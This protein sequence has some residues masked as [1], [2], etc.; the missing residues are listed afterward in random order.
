MGRPLTS[1]DFGQEGLGIG[2]IDA[3]GIQDIVVGNPG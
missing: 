3:D 2:D 1:R